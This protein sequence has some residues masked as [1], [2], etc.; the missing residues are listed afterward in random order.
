MAVRSRA[1]AAFSA[2]RA[3]P[4]GVVAGPAAFASTRLVVVTQAD[5]P[6]RSSLYV[7]FGDLGGR[8]G[9]PRLLATAAVDAS[10]VPA[11]RGVRLAVSARGEAVVAWR[12]G[13]RGGGD[14]VLVSRRRAGGSFGAP[15]ALGGPLGDF[16][17]AIGAGGD[18]VVAWEHGGRVVR[19]RFMARGARGFG[20]VEDVRSRSARV[21]LRVAVAPSGRAW[22]AWTAQRRTEGGTIFPA[23]VQVAMRPPG[24][25]R[26]GRA[27]LLARAPQTSEPS[28]PALALAH[29]GTAIVA[30]AMHD[31]RA[32][33][34][35][36][37]NVARVPQAG[38]PK[39]AR[40]ARFEAVEPFGNVTAA[41]GDDGR[42][43]VAWTQVADARSGASR[44]VAATH[45]R[46]SG[47][48][49]PLLVASG[50]WQSDLMVA[51]PPGERQALIAYADSLSGATPQA[52]VRAATP[53]AS[54][55]VAGACPAV[56]E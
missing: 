8:F 55:A 33:A 25:R 42:A 50:R 14:R 31:W 23:Y 37:I 19:A 30:W 20:R 7:R 38:G 24:A 13:R 32:P 27:R 22:I 45:V 18:A 6:R 10:G 36:Q 12:V 39:V 52:V 40:L 34:A 44:I 35:T 9:R 49:A 51:Y 17:L 15:V 48:A 21:A 28:P 46:A 16:A 54:C 56:A 29:S 4:G 47:W 41:A 26:F 53:P 43:T 2:E 11:I 3:L 1:G 5:R